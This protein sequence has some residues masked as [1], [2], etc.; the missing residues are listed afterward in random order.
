MAEESIKEELLGTK[1]A[2][3]VSWKEKLNFLKQHMTKQRVE[4][5][6]TIDIITQSLAS[7]SQFD[8]TQL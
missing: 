4:F 2:P 1:S 7:G 5:I 3:L 6:E 8:Q